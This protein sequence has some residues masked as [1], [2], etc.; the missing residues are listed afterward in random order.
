M[1]PGYV[2]ADS[3]TS[4]SLQSTCSEHVPTEPAPAFR[5]CSVWRSPDRSPKLPVSSWSRSYPAIHPQTVSSQT[6]HRDPQSVARS[7]VVLRIASRSCQC[8]RCLNS[9]VTEKFHH[10]H[11]IMT[12]AA[13]PQADLR[14]S[15][16]L[17]V[18]LSGVQRCR[19]DARKKCW[20]LASAPAAKS[21]H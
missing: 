7:R 5:L 4:G 17:R 10:W 14:V 15:C 11:P 19:K 8:L 9:Y 13:I 6:Q 12:Y 2:L 1:V 3:G 18:T 20:K 16:V 21:A